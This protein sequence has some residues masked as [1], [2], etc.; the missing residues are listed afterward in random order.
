MTG[1]L[2]KKDSEIKRFLGIPENKEIVGI[3]P[4]GIPVYMP[5]CPPKADVK[6]KVRWFGS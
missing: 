2:K 1:P 4:I 6:T 5:E 3:I